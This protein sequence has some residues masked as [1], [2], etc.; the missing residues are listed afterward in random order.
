MVKISIRYSLFASSP[1]SFLQRRGEI[2]DQVVGMFE[3]GGETDEA[4]A[5]AEFGAG[6]GRQ[7][8]MR[9]GRGMRD[10]AL[11]V[12]EI[13]R[14]Q[15]QL[16]GVEAAERRRLAALDLEADQRRAGAHLLLHHRRLRMILA[17]GIQ[18]PR[19][20]RMLR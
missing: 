2:L 4:L 12:A 1:S 7:P 15:R 17:T 16:K 20:F 6:L 5:D 3:A 13:V 10:E 14:D 9:G 18:E 11:G 8:L 19:D